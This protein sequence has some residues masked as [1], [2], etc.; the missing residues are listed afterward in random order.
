MADVTATFAARD[1]S[2]N[3]TVTQLQNRLNSFQG[4]LQGF[5]NEV[6]N[7]GATF[8][9]I[10]IAVGAVVGV[11]RSVQAALSSFQQ[12]L[13]NTD[14]LN[15]FANRVNA[16]PGDL[17]LLQT[18]FQNAGSSADALEP[19]INRLN[20]EL[21]KASQG[22]SEAQEKFSRLGLNFEILKTQSPTEQL[23]AVGNAIKELPTPADQTAAAMAFFGRSGASLVNVL[24]QLQPEL[25][26]ARGQLGSYPEVLNSS[27]A[28]MGRLN[29]NIVQVQDKVNQFTTGALAALEPLLSNIAEAAARVDFAGMGQNLGQTLTSTIDAWVGML[30][31]K[32][33]EIAQLLLGN[34]QDSIAIVADF[35]A[36]KLAQAFSFAGNYFSQI[37]QS[38]AINSAMDYLANALINAVARFD[39]AMLDMLQNTISPA[40]TSLLSMSA[41]DAQNLFSLAFS[42]VLSAL[43]SDFVQFLSN[44]VAFVASSFASA[45]TQA[46]TTTAQEFQTGYNASFGNVIEGLR[47]GLL[48]VIAETKAN[49][50]AAS[51]N[52]QIKVTSAATIASE[53]SALVNTDLFNSADSAERIRQRI[54]DAQMSGAQLRAEIETAAAAI[55]GV[56]IDLNTSAEDAGKLQASFEE[57]KASAQIAQL[58]TSEM[59]QDGQSFAN[60]IKTAKGDIQA[61]VDLMVGPNGLTDRFNQAMERVQELKDTIGSLKT[62]NEDDA[63][64]RKAER[65]MDASA[66]K[67]DR[68]EDYANDLERRGQWSAADNAR[69][70]AQESFERE[71]RESEYEQ[72]S[73][74]LR[75]RDNQLA[76]EKT[77]FAERR[78]AQKQADADHQQR[79]KEMND[80]LNQEDQATADRIREQQ[81]DA[82][83]KFFGKTQEAASAIKEGGQQAAD[84]LKNAVKGLTDTG[85]QALALEATLEKCR[86]FLESIDK[87]LPQHALS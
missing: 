52:F 82:A 1:E 10:G 66:R 19:A 72:H 65:S 87:K 13:E 15:D 11:F 17:A 54:A 77:S 53:K 64:M 56:P 68:A 32:G 75:D 5:N 79:M 4:G 49:M 85:Q 67:Y 39:L 37:F 36:D 20:N 25:A 62:V 59:S 24:T 81:L 76:E 42:N 31:M 45:L 78:N 18:A 12:T 47:G 46:A 14:A 55:D 71:Q 38:G 83:E 50:D 73:E 29:D 69:Q 74:E 21:G 51:D 2:F 23:L 44:P 41:S 80:R 63:Y 22:S 48:P 60:N 61:A 33:P 3:S 26:N 43:A 34:M 57:A 27:A 8:T 40:I 6:A 86:V 70:R 35:L 84:A 9:K 58:K 30:S 28:A 7:I 16:L